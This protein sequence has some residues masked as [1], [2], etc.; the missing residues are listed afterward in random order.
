MTSKII[1]WFAH[2][3]IPDRSRDWAAYYE[4]QQEDGQYGWGK[5]ES[6]AIEDLKISYPEEDNC[7]IC[8]DYHAGAIPLSCKTGDGK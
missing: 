8:G 6:E 4:D 5:T 1:T 7:D 3:P 2:S